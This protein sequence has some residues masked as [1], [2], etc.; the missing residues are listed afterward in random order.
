MLYIYNVRPY[1][2]VYM[3]LYDNFSCQLQVERKKPCQSLH[4]QKEKWGRKVEALDTA[5]E[6]YIEKGYLNNDA[7]NYIPAGPK[8]CTTTY[9]GFTL[10]DRQR[11]TLLKKYP[12]IFIIFFIS[13]PRGNA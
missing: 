10:D 4:L 13:S 1:N 12:Q 2:R 3:V 8:L 7:D 5:I 9:K 11:L 6:I